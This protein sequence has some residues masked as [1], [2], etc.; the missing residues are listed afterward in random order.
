L[1]FIKCISRNI[2]T[3]FIKFIIRAFEHRLRAYAGAGSNTIQTFPSDE[4]S[5]DDGNQVNFV[6]AWRPG[7]PPRSDCIIK[8][9]KGKVPKVF[10]AILKFQICISDTFIS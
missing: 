2:S 9:T 8:L 3:L 4:E 6:S 10:K 7:Q 5:E 1:N